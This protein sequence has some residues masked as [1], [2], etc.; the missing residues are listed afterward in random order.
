MN[1]LDG[2]NQITRAKKLQKH[3]YSVIESRY[4]Y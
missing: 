2:K 1:A 4:D 3:I